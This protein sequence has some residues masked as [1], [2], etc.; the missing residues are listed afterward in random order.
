MNLLKGLD[1]DS[2]T[3]QI[4][5]WPVDYKIP[6]RVKFL[7]FTLDADLSSFLEVLHPRTIQNFRFYIYD[8]FCSYSL[9]TPFLKLL[10]GCTI[11]WFFILRMNS[12]IFMIFELSE[13]NFNLSSS[14][15]RASKI[16]QNDTNFLGTERRTSTFLTFA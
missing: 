9:K 13:W 16:V 8:Y 11:P 15:K 1:M 4:Q 2:N 7:N 14:Y 5:I 10:A 6:S 12:V 3:W